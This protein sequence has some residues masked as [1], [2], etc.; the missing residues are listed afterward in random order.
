MRKKTSFQTALSVKSLAILLLLALINSGGQAA[1]QKPDSRQARFDG[2]KVHYDSYGQGDEAVVFIHGAMSDR[3]YWQPQLPALTRNRVLVID[4]PG[5]GASDKPRIAY[6]LDLLAQAIDA[7]LRDAG[8]KRAT[9]VGHSLGVAVARQFYRRYP[10]KTRALVFV[11][12]ALR[13]LAPTPEIGENFLT[14]FRGADYLKAAE[15]FVNTFLTTPQTAA[16][17]RQKIHAKWAATPQHVMVSV[18]EHA[19]L[20]QSDPEVWQTDK[21]NVPTLAIYTKMPYVPPDNEQFFRSL[22]SNIDYQVWEG[23]T[24]NLTLE[25]SQEFNEALRAFLKKLDAQKK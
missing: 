17:V 13:P 19:L 15:N 14:P 7:V 24:H 6:K 21:I 11:D 9:L 10:A 25:K 1:D 23:A 2:H 20:P 8:V 4:L 12:G 16:E 18:L 3:T 22:A 5:H